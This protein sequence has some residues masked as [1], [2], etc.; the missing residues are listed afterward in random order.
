MLT[1]NCNFN[2]NYFCFVSLLKLYYK[3]NVLLLYVMTV[4]TI[5]HA[6]NCVAII[7]ITRQSYSLHFTMH[8]CIHEW[9]VLMLI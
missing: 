8:T 6:D 1:F 5:G 9:C 4:S 2:Y 7:S 3:V